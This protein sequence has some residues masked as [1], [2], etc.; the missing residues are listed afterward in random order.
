MACVLYHGPGARQA[1]VEE[2]DRIGVLVKPPFGDDGL[3][4][5]EAREVVGLL[6][7]ATLVKLS[8]FVVGP[9][10]RANVNASDALLKSIEHPPCKYTA[11]ILWAHDLGEVRDTIRSRCF[12]RW[13]SSDDDDDDYGD[14]DLEEDATDMLRA[15]QFGNLWMIPEIAKRR[16]GQERELLAFFADMLLAETNN[17]DNLLLWERL[18]LVAKHRNPTMLEVVAALMP[19][20]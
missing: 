16:S 3:K 8:V 6:R 1:A 11:L 9:V 10:D 18:R 13:V 14:E 19:V 20:T 17:A 2:A 12:D 5:P 15:A 4:V 7:R